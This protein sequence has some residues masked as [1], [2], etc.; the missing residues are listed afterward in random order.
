MLNHRHFE[1]ILY[2]TYADLRVEAERTYIGFL[3][4]VLDPIV[5]MCVYYLAFGV[6]FNIKTEDYVPFLF[7]GLVPWRWHLSSMGHAGNSLISGHNLMQQVH[8]PKI[9]FPIVTL[10]TDLVKFAFVFVILLAFLWI[11]GRPVGL[12]YLALPFLLFVHILFIAATSI[13][14]ASIVP[15]AADLRLLVDYLMRLLF[16]L[17][18]IFWSIERVP[19]AYHS[20][21]RLNPFFSIIEAYRDILLKNEWPAWS[22]L[23]VIAAVSVTGILVGVRV[24]AKND[25][26]YPR[27]V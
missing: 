17:S 9:I 24:I 26:N 12:S 21:V 25:R 16:F 8:L 10:L 1:L 7:T 2:K 4:W 3:W 13:V 27:L 18:G 23:L 19:E 6:L 11:Y 15:F 14:L 22:T 20:Y 5:S